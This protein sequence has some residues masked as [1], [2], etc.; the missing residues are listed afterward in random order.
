MKLKIKFIGLL[1]IC[2]LSATESNAQEPFLGEIKMFAGNFAPRGWAFCD[3]QLLAISQ[4]TALFSLLGTM[5]GGDGRTSF[6]LP[7]LRGR[8]PVSAGTGPGLS[9]RIQGARYGTEYINLNILQLPSHS[10]LATAT[11]TGAGSTANITYSANNAI[12]ETPEAG[13]VPAIGNYAD[14]LATKKVK[15]FGPAN[16]TIVGQTINTGGGTPTV[17]IQNT[18]NNQ[19]VFISQ[20]TTVVRY[21]ICIQGLFPSRS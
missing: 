2:L 10:H 13:D 3:G 9:T 11:Q 17:T 18:G 6:G 5:Y 14:G 4:N 16:N 7:D 19:A 8:V 12:H 15:S 20:P 1:F 21:I